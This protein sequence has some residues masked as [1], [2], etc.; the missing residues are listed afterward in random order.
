MYHREHELLIQ[1]RVCR[2]GRP[3]F[4]HCLG[5][6]LSD[7]A[8]FSRR[9]DSTGVE[10]KK[11]R[12]Q[13]SPQSFPLDFLRLCWIRP[14]HFF[15]GGTRYIGLPDYSITDVAFVLLSVVSMIA[16]IIARPLPFFFATIWQLPNTYSGG[17]DT[18]Y[19]YVS[20]VAKANGRWTTN[21]HG[22][23]TM[24]ADVSRSPTS[25]Q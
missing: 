16:V 11:K 2:V 23:A 6:M 14:G 19:A 17:R 25:A 24:G 15:P 3:F 9:A 8:D 4:V 10:V 12:V 1:I 21:A 13:V 22:W 7:G 20:L 5:Q 18:V